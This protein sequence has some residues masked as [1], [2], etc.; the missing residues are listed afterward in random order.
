MGMTPNREQTAA[1]ATPTF[2]PFASELDASP[3]NDTA[4]ATTF[5]LSPLASTVSSSPFRSVAFGENPAPA[6]NNSGTVAFFGFTRQFIAPQT[7]TSGEVIS[8]AFATDGG[9]PIALL[10]GGFLR[11]PPVGNLVINDRGD[12]AFPRLSRI[13]RSNIVILRG[14]EERRFEPGFGSV[15]PSI[16]DSGKIAVLGAISAIGLPEAIFVGTDTPA[17]FSSTATLI[18]RINGTTA[19]FFT[20]LGAPSLNDSDTIAFTAVE[21]LEGGD[22]RSILTSDLQGNFKTRVDD[23]GI[24][25]SFGDPLLND[26]DELAFV[27]TLDNGDRAI[28]RSSGDSFNSLV[29]TATGTFNRFE[30]ISFNNQNNVAFLAEPSVGGEA[31]AVV[32]DNT[33]VPVIATGDSLL[34]SRVVDL[35]FSR[36]G[37]NDQNQLAFYARLENGV[38]GIFRAEPFRFNFDRGEEIYRDSGNQTVVTGS[39]NDRITVGGD[40]NRISAGDGDNGIA[41]GLRDVQFRAIAPWMNAFSASFAEHSTGRNRVEAGSGNDFIRVA[42]GDNRISAGDGRNRVVVERGGNTVDT[43]KDD[44]FVAIGFASESEL[45]KDFGQR[46]P[47][48]NLKGSRVATGNGSDVII[49]G[50]ANDTVDAGNGS[51][52]IQDS[53]GQNIILSGNGNDRMTLGDGSDRIIAGDGSNLIDAGSGNNLINA[54]AGND[55]VTTGSGDDIIQAGS[56]VN[57]ITAGDGDNQITT[58]DGRDSIVV[59]NGNNLLLAGKGDNFIRTGDGNNWLYVDQGNNTIITGGGND[60]I[61]ISDGRSSVNA[62]GGDDLIHGGLGSNTI[63]AEAGNDTIIAGRLANYINLFGTGNDTVWLTGGSDRILLWSGT[64]DATIWNYTPNA[65]FELEFSLREKGVTTRQT[66]NDTQIFAAATDDLLVT[67]KG[68]IASEIVFAS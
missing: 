8:G 5:F 68:A 21:R 55:T 60:R 23:R 34:S 67:V 40:Q 4:V 33:L 48:P 1:I 45:F 24:F 37:L 52:V 17:G 54:G 28:F 35:S 13:V 18:A 64:G 29:S 66:G 11:D 46:S 47:I 25:Q 9:A 63:T 38:Q 57:V 43:G 36:Q 15:F 2:Q 49:L 3:A 31:I 32:A 20:D 16:N 22:R 30:A 6:I 58:G 61:S 10:P 44:D 53:G 12:I 50:S 19:P 42:A 65:Q 41:I 39:G 26:R 62:G 27:A 51:N 14:S 7:F 59:G 56:G